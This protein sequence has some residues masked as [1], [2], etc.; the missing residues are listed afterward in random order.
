MNSLSKTEGQTVKFKIYFNE[1]VIETLVAFSNAKGG[2]VYLGISDKGKPQGI[3]V[4]DLLSRNY[5]S[6]SRNKLVA[7]AFK[8]YRHDRTLWIGHASA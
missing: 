2:I 3:I 6:K 4:H 1:D 7:R 5:T 8:E